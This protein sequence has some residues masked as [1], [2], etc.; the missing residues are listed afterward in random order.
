MG[1]SACSVC[2][3]GIKIAHEDRGFSEVC[4][5]QYGDWHCVSILEIDSA[6]SWNFHKVV[7]EENNCPVIAAQCEDS[8]FAIL[9]LYNN[10]K[11]INY[12]NIGETYMGETY[13]PDFDAWTPYETQGKTLKEFLDEHKDFIF[14]ERVLIDLKEVFGFPLINIPW[15]K[16]D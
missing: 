7:G 14:A 8:D 16:L 2:A 9:Y 5:Q 15:L 6:E 10:G 12:F 1:L 3:K 4:E 11:L 13:V